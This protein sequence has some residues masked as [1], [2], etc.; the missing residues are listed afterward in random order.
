M[1]KKKCREK[2]GLEYESQNHDVKKTIIQSKRIKT[3]EK[4]S[5]VKQIENREKYECFSTDEN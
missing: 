3:L 2:Y 4:N 1:L 5:G